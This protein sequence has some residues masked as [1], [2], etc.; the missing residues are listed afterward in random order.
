MSWASTLPGEAPSSASISTLSWLRIVRSTSSGGSDGGAKEPLLAGDRVPTDDDR[1]ANNLIQSD[2]P[3]IVA[4]AR[5]IAPQET[6]PWQIATQLEAAVKGHIVEADYSQAFA[7]A[8]D[9]VEHRKGDCTEH[10]VLLAALCRARGIPAYMVFAD[11]T[12]LEI[13]AGKPTT[14]AALSRVHGVGGAKLAL[15]GHMLLEI[16]G[17]NASA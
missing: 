7:S 2:N 4:M 14:E 1:T 10:A 6:E 3:K 16:V 11:R 12:L 8:A 5:S 13:A 15:Y 9:V 17:R